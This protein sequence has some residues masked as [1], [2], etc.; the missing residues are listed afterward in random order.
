MSER[1][2]AEIWIGGKVPAHLMPEL[3]AKICAEISDGLFLDWILFSSITKEKLFHLYDEQA[4]PGKFNNLEAFLKEHGIPFTRR[5]DSGVNSEIIEYRPGQD[6]VYIPID[7]DGKPVIDAS[8]LRPVDKL[9]TGALEQ[10]RHTN[11]L[12]TERMES[13]LK[14][15]QQQLRAQLP[16]PLESFEI[17]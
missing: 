2:T 11:L 6:I 10:L 5:T 15:A 8:V 12:G 1:M 16:P 7:A 14:D 3:C 9:L 17:V 4:S 13:I